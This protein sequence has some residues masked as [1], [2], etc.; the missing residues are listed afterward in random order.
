MTNKVMDIVQPKDNWERGYAH[1]EYLRAGL[2]ETLATK[3][4][5]VTILKPCDCTLDEMIPERTSF[6]TNITHI[7]RKCLGGITRETNDAYN[8]DGGY[9]GFDEDGNE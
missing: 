3:I 5:V 7:C 9:S 1:L 6:Q 2:L 4:D 8:R